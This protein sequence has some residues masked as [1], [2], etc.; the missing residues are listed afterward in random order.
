[1]TGDDDRE[2]QERLADDLSAPDLRALLVGR[3]VIACLK[4]WIHWL[5]MLALGA[6][7]ATAPEWVALCWRWFRG[8]K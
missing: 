6:A 5:A 3:V 2:R 1:V 8:G 4:N 7:T